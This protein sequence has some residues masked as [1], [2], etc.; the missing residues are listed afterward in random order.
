ML[1]AIRIL[2]RGRLLR[3]I[4]VV[5]AAGLM[6]AGANGAAAAAGH[7][8]GPGASTAAGIIS[9]VAGGVGGPAKATQVSLSPY[10]VFSGTGGLYLADYGS[11]AR[12]IAQ[13][14]QLTPVAGTGV[15]GPVGDKGAATNASM[16]TSTV[17]QD[18][19]GN[20]LITDQGNERVRV[21]AAHTGTFY[22]QA[23]TA[24]DIYTVAGDGQFGFSGDG[25]PATAAALSTPSGVAVDGA[26]NLVIT[27]SE[28]SRVRVVAAHTGTFYG[29]AM[30]AGDIYTVAGTGP[31]GGYG[32]DGGPATAAELNF[33][34]GIAV[35][36]A[37]NLVI[38]D[39]FNNRVRVVAVRTG[40]FYGQAMTTGDIYTVAGDGTQGYSG[41]GGPATAAQL[42]RSQ[43]VA[44]DG[45]GNLLIAD[46]ANNRVRV[47]A[48]HMGIFYGQAMTAGDIYTVAG[49][50]T[51]GYSGDGGPAT[52]AML[53]G[54]KGVAL[55]GAGNL[56]IADEVNDRVRV[57]AAQTGT[58]YAQAMT[59]GDIY[60]VASNGNTPGFGAGY[61]GDGR[62][63]TT[64]QLTF[65][66]GVA[67]DGA[68]N[69]VITDY[70]NSAVR[71]VAARTGT[72]YQKK[73]TAGHIYKV[74]GGGAAGHLGDRGPAT[75]ARLHGPWGV[76]VD[77]AGNLLI[78]DALHN[79]VRV[80]AARTGTFYAQAM[81]AGDIYTVAGNGQYGFSGDG[82]P[83]TAAE[84]G[85]PS[86]VAVD[87]TGNLLIA[88]S[89]NNRVRVVA[90]RTG[91][92]YGKAMTA[93]R[94]YTVAGNG[95]KGYSGDGG[96]AAAA[97]LNLPN[98]V[99]VDGTGNLL[100]ADTT[101]NRIR[102]VAART[103]T[104]YGKAMTAGHIYTLAGNGQFGFSGDG[105]PATAAALNVPFGVTVD[106]SG[107]LVIADSFNSRIRVVAA[108]DGTFYGKAMTAGDIYTVAGNNAIGYSGDGGPGIKAELNTP[109][110]VTM[111]G[112]GN[113]VI[114][115]TFSQ[116]IRELAGAATA[117][118]PARR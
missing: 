25:G 2:G 85:T 82:G 117:R 7:R 46:T 12:V 68:G 41:D 47:V 67:V 62:L 94:I 58:F 57:V 29:Q 92:F 33:P 32:G 23:M 15:P 52:A 17:A 75:K 97:A 30:T 53:H 40:T 27:D 3:G 95:T 106:A 98:G 44:V 77:G 78:T 96:P 113:L 28:N 102:V 35:D 60:T 31:G 43:A 83:A 38:A 24:G 34:N 56:V 74:V 110:S 21:A 39:E 51:Q 6:L 116:R 20:L 91:T 19:S 9:T 87:G 49:D 36:A 18:K 55:D 69:L 81:T 16:I 114:A 89:A 111:D 71:V 90:A 80:V 4:P 100:I 112:A 14:D 88:D 103:G 63:A 22:G 79:R 108:H 48:A 84:F 115:D 11:V 37:G 109:Y 64:G 104:F 66:H 73:M 118:L 8:G 105:G 76:A 10:G 1:G 107:N 65:P 26:G 54:P 70:G 86:G 99:A 13:T 5:V 45:T 93:G 72:F 42:A 59:A 61:S 101:N 50:G